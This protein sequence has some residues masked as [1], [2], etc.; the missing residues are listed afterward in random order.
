MINFG[1]LVLFNIYNAHLKVSISSGYRSS[2]KDRSG[3]PQTASR[4]KFY[5]DNLQARPFAGIS[6]SY[7][8]DD[9]KQTTACTYTFPLFNIYLL[10]AKFNQA[11]KLLVG[12]FTKTGGELAYIDPK[13]GEPIRIQIEGMDDWISLVPT[14]H[15][16]VLSDNST[17]KLPAISLSTSKFTINSQTV[18]ATLS[19]EEFLALND[20]I[21]HMDTVAVLND[22][23][24]IGL[25]TNVTAIT[26]TSAPAPA[27]S[28]QSGHSSNYSYGKDYQ[29][30]TE[31]TY[32]SPAF[33]KAPTQPAPQPAPSVPA[34]Q[35]AVPQPANATYPTQ[36]AVANPQ[37]AAVPAK[38]THINNDAEQINKLFSDADI[39]AQDLM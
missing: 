36:P 33:S 25:L 35:P 29:T 31:N 19:K 26:G 21:Q 7:L 1:T 10:R 13:V 11:A 28:N 17:V 38:S 12:G 3:Q 5:K 37:P 39:D 6:F 30:K 8:S 32:H 2:Y 23:T 20:T 27:Y 14:I 24:I 22:L 9:F 34:P 18:A 4:V 15:S 16:F